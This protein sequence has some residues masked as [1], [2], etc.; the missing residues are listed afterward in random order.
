MKRI[1][2]LIILQSLLAYFGFA[3]NQEDLFN[4]SL[5]EL[6][7]VEISISSKTSSSIRETPGIVTVITKEDIENSGARDLLE[8][9]QLYTPG[10]NFG[11]DVEGAVGLGIRGLWAHEGKFLLMVDG[12]EFNDGMFA[13]VPFGNHFTLANVQK[14][15]IIRGP[16][17]SVYGGFAGIGVI[18]VITKQ[19]DSDSGEAAYLASFTG[20]QFAFNNLSFNSSV[21]RSDIKLNFSGVYGKGARSEKGYT[22]I[23]GDWRGLN[24]S[25]DIQTKQ[26]GLSAN[27]KSL[28]VVALFDDYSYDQVDLWDA[29][30]RGTPLRES[31]QS[32]FFQTS[33]DFKVS[34]KIKIVPRVNYKWQQPWHLNVIDQGYKNSKIYTK[35][36]GSIVSTYTDERIN[37][38]IGIDFSYEKLVQRAF[39]DDTIEEVFKTGKD[40][41]DYKNFATYGQVQLD[42]KIFNLNIGARFDNSS[43]YGSAFVPRFALTK[44]AKGFHFKA[45]YSQS[46][47]VPGGIIPNRQPEGFNIEPEKGTILEL[48]V[49]VK[50][51]LQSYFTLNLFDIRF[52]KVII[53][54]TDISGI[55]SYQN[56]GKVGSHGLEAEL[57]HSSKL[58]SA[59]LNFA[60]Y[61]RIKSTT[62]SSFFVPGNDGYFLAFSPI[63]VNTSLSYLIN[64]NYRVG[65]NFSYFGK[66]YAYDDDSGI[67][68]KYDPNFLL[69][70][71]FTVNRFLIDGMRLTLLLTN[72]LNTDYLFMQPYNGGHAPL[73]GLD[74]SIGVNIK[75]Q[76]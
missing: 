29:V 71:N 22:D 36:A 48:E 25:S 62:D 21:V 76:F 73:S 50:L 30:Y 37:G 42:A 2:L 9:L 41:L 12:Q 34:D 64:N 18:N 74:R 24:N 31:F 53:Y 40:F 61:R 54:Q 51:P 3:Q 5:E 19:H 13:T 14:V 57:K 68:A 69:N 72:V 46:F 59:N 47:R 56:F 45:M 33:Y 11:V 38:I 66:R 39:I 32:Q 16:G 58:F 55:G 8:L 6:M 17:S 28:N 60:Y 49:G 7:N 43:E 67:P 1:S 63:R 4:L 26:F 44:A 15:E 20:N 70:L 65:L 23:Y 10:F 35:T 75:Y 52:E 27:Y